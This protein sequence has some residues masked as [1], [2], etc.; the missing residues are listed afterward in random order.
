MAPIYQLICENLS[1]AG[2]DA[3][4]IPALTIQ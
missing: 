3:E 2:N 4:I 1:C